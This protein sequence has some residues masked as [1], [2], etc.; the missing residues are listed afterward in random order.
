MEARLNR[1]ADAV[2]VP[3]DRAGIARPAPVS[4]FLS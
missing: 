3:G 4:A 1:K 2:M